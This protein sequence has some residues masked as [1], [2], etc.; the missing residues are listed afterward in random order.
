[1]MEGAEIELDEEALE[2]LRALEK[3]ARAKTKFGLMNL[4]MGR[5][6]VAE[7]DKDWLEI[8]TGGGSGARTNGNGNGNGHST[9]TSAATISQRLDNAVE[10][11]VHEEQYKVL[12]PDCQNALRF[13]EGCVKC[14]SCGFSQ[15]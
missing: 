13:A 11:S 2:S 4:V 15:C 1:M 8:R 5:F 3:Y 9:G 10:S 7:L 6:D 14:E 12:C